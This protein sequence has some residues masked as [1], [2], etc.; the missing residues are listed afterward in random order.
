MPGEDPPRRGVE[1]RAWALH[2]GLALLSALCVLGLVW[3][4]A[5]A[6]AVQGQDAP[7][8]DNPYGLGI[9]ATLALLTGVLLGWFFF[10]F[11]RLLLRGINSDS[12]IRAL[13]VVLLCLGATLGA[14]VFFFVTCFSIRTALNR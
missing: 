13:A 11:R 6:K 10:L 3:L 4:Y 1:W 9:V 5:R 14:S 2:G 8:D 12:A 7:F